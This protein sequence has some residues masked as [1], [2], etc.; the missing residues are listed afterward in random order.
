VT[1]DPDPCRDEPVQSVA[2]VVGAAVPDRVTRILAEALVAAGVAVLRAA[3]SGCA[4]QPDRLLCLHAEIDAATA[5]RLLQV[6][7]MPSPPILGI[8]LGTGSP[9]GGAAAAASAWD[10]L[11]LSPD[12]LLIWDGVSPPHQLL[13]RLGRTSPPGAGQARD[14]APAAGLNGAATAGGIVLELV[15]RNGR[16]L[17]IPPDLPEPLLRQILARL[18]D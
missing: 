1:Q 6:A 8:A 10:R 16:V 5:H 14:P 2:L 15:L 13:R 12:S 9:A 7:A 3:D 11:G 17:R 4:V 18:D